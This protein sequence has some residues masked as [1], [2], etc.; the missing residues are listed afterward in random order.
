MQPR[1]E[2]VTETPQLSMEQQVRKQTRKA[3]VKTMSF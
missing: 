1:Q 3:G 2:V